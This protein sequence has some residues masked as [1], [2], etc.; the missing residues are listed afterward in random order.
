MKT[1]IITGLV[2]IAVILPCVVIGQIPFQVLLGIVAGA[3][4]FEMLSICNRPKANIYLYPL[5][6]IFIYYSLFFEG[7][8]LIPSEILIIYLIVLLAC[9]MFDDGMNYLRLCYYFCAGVLVAMG[10]HMLY[11][12]RLTYGFEYILILA[13]ATF[14]T[15]TGAYFTGMFFGKHKL[16]PRLSPKK[17]IEGSLGGM[18]LGT[19][20]SVA[21]GAYIQV[22]I[23]ISLLI[24]ICFV[25]TITSQ[26][27]DLTF[28]S[29]KRT[30]EVKD[31]SQLLPGHG[32]VLDRFDSILFNAMVFGLLLHFVAMVVV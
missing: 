21:Y 4:V 28:S 5:V 13:L 3:A 9:S 15:D 12:L 26:I 18:L 16:N 10:L 14:G 30:F 11:Q 1:R 20:L 23:P 32:G 2:L 25:L 27:G 31:Y 22:N 19:V 24:A 7:A 8:L 29:I 6:G 17:T